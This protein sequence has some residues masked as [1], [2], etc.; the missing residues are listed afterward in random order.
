MIRGVRQSD[1]IS[2]SAHM[3]VFLSAQLASVF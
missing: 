2:G 3:L 1:V